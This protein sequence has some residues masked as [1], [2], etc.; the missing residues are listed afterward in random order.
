M[1]ICF[2]CAPIALLVSLT[3]CGGG[4]DNSPAPPAPVFLS[5]ARVV[6][7]R[8]CEPPRVTLAQVDAELLL[9]GIET[10][11]R[12]CAWDGKTTLTACLSPT[13]YFRVIETTE[14]YVTRARQLGYKLNSEYPNVIPADCPPV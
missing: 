6:E 9:A 12:S 11:S 8:T 10:R 1:H 2:R 13:T 7:N 5:M 14:A 3:A 4:G